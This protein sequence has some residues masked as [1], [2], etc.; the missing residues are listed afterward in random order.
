M[1]KATLR[2]F[3]LA[4]CLHTI[5]AHADKPTKIWAQ[6]IFGSS[7]TPFKMA[8]YVDELQTESSNEVNV[9]YG[10]NYNKLYSLVETHAVDVVYISFSSVA[11]RLIDKYN[12]KIIAVADMTIGVFTIKGI[13][14][15]DVKRLGYMNGSIA[16]DAIKTREDAKLVELVTFDSLTSMTLAMLNGDIDAMVSSNLAVKM[17][18]EGSREKISNFQ[19]LKKMGQCVI[20]ASPGFTESNGFGRFQQTILANHPNSK[21][22]FVDKMG[23]SN[24]YRNAKNHR[25]RE[26]H[27]QPLGQAPLKTNQDNPAVIN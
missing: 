17:L 23:L 20:L 5:F 2:L 27:R 13:T 12:F 18:P 9:T 21:S 25:D 14:L 8:N 7:M 4:L 10:N 19:P 3:I 22:I 11:H 15:T 24:W 1:N 16:E 26:N 6:S